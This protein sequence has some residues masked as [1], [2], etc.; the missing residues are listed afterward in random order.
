[1]THEEHISSKPE[2]RIPVKPMEMEP[3]ECFGFQM[4]WMMEDSISNPEDVRKCFDCPMFD[5]CNRLSTVRTLQ[6]MRFEMRRS[7]RGLRESLGG[8]HSQ[9]PFW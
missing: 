7:T 3:R 1:M 6:Q 9:N 4:S 5:R 2:E 8:A